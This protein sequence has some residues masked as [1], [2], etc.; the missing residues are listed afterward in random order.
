MEQKQ[1]RHRAG[2]GHLLLFGSYG[3]TQARCG[4]GRFGN[5]GS[6]AFQPHYIV[7]A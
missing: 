4:H 2:A 5:R 1:P 3:A 6:C 7:A